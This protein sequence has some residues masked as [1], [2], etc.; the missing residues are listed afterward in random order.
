MTQEEFKHIS[1][2]TRG[3][4]VGLAG[5]F[6]RATGG[7][8]EAEDIVQ[9][10]LLALWE[11]SEKGYPIRDPK[12]LAIKITKNI[13]VSKYRKRKLETCPVKDDAFPG[14]PSAEERVEA[15]D[16]TRVKKMLY[17]RLSG[18]QREFM[19]LRNDEGMSLDEIAKATGRPKS[20]IKV[21]ISNSRKKMMEQLKK[22]I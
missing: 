4:L 18:S 8:E 19:T 7:P 3:G 15:T 6:I 22:L 16:N 13:C 1:A 9:E 17:D 2:A 12:A 11:L 5:R 10:A 20:S 14:G 21:S